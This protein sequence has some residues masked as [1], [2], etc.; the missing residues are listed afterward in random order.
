[1]KKIIICFYLIGILLVVCSCKK[2]NNL[3]QI[4]NVSSKDT[5]KL[6]YKNNEANIYKIELLITGNI[7]GNAIIYQKDNHN[8]IMPIELKK[9]DLNLR[10]FDDWYSTEC[11]LEYEP[12]DVT[13]GEIHIEYKFYNY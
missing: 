11:I 7:N 2:N 3:A 9:G 6:E 4:N 1:M 8:F 13:K 10:I 12:R 5:L